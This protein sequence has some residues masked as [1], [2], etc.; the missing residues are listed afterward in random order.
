MNED[1]K[2]YID[3]RDTVVEQ[4]IKL[5]IMS[6]L[7][8]QVM[9]LAPIIFFLGGIYQNANS[10]L[11]LLK[12]QKVGTDDLSRRVTQ[13]EERQREARA[14]SKTKGFIPFTPDPPAIH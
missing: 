4:K 12:I 5:W 1:I 13:I 7:I 9:A 8:A 14:W 10:S 11:E 6:S 3:Q 2:Q